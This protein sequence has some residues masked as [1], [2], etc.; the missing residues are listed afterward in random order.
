MV[1]QH[2]IFTLLLL[3]LAQSCSI[4][5][6]RYSNGF[7][8]EGL[9]HN[10]NGKHIAASNDNK[11]SVIQTFND[12]ELEQDSCVSER[13][14]LYSSHGEV[15]KSIE[16]CSNEKPLFK[17]TSRIAFNERSILSS[18]KITTS[19]PNEKS[20]I[21]QKRRSSVHPD[22]FT[23][24]VSGLLAFG[25]LAGIFLTGFTSLVLFVSLLIAMLF[26]AFLASRLANRAFKDM[27]YARDRYSGK[28]LAAAGMV[29]GVLCIVAFIGLMI[30]AAL[31][32]AFTFFA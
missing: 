3:L 31:G 19:A 25:C 10:H 14:K 24:F 21:P 13:E 5:K 15:K 12:I 4:E 17:K 32:L 6:R 2:F 22:A 16:S 27:H 11:R 30:I 20:Q 7:Y 28:G 29:M 8:I 18:E 26:F 9:H 1:R 23:S